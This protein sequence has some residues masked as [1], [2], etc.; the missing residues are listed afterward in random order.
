MARLKGRRDALLGCFTLAFSWR[1]RR[2]FHDVFEAFSEN[3]LEK[4]NRKNARSSLNPGPGLFQALRTPNYPAKECH[5]LLRAV[6]ELAAAV[7]SSGGAGHVSVTPRISHVI[8]VRKRDS[9]TSAANPPPPRFCS[10][11]AAQT[12]NN[13]PAPSSILSC[14]LLTLTV[15]DVSVKTF[16]A[17]HLPVYR[18]DGFEPQ[19]PEQTDPDKRH[20]SVPKTYFS[21]HET[22]ME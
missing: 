13:T 10:I 2:Y 14:C 1:F 4:R 16:A 21:E 15:Q 18:N 7:L 9:C 6:C 11:C 22:I 12:E 8:T 20:H 3:A 5:P 17:I 19:Y